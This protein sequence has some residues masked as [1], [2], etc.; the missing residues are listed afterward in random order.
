M[1]FRFE[2][3]PNGG[4]RLIGEIA[5]HRLCWLEGRNG[6]GKTLAVRLLQLVTGE[7]PYANAPT[8]WRSLREHLGPTTIVVT[9]F[10][11][12]EELEVQL[13]PRNWPESPI[14]EAPLGTA[15]LDGTRISFQEVRRL[16][17]VSRI[18]GDET[19]TTRFKDYIGTDAVLVGRHNERLRRKTEELGEANDALLAAMNGLSTQALDEL[20]QRQNQ[21]FNNRREVADEYRK[22]T[23][24]VQELET[25]E[26]LTE[27]L[28]ELRGQGP[29]LRVSLENV[30]RRLEEYEQRRTALEAQQRE[31]L[32][33]VENEDALLSERDRLLRRRERQEANAARDSAKAEGVLDELRLPNDVSAVRAALAEAEAE[34][35]ELE[36]NQAALKVPPDVAALIDRVRSPLDIVQDSAISAEVIAVVEDH[37]I[38]AN[39]LRDGL[40]RRKAE[41][42]AHRQ[43]S[44]QEE[45]EARIQALDEKLGQLRKAGRLLDSVERASERIED[46]EHQINDVSK[47]LEENSSDKYKEVVAELDLVQQSYLDQVRERASLR[48]KLELMNRLGSESE[49]ESRTAVLGE[50]LGVSATPTQALHQARTEVVML[51]DRLK[52]ADK[53]LEAAEIAHND[54]ERRLSE[55]TELM[56]NSSAYEWLRRD[57]SGRVPSSGLALREALGRI[58]NLTSA[59]Q[60][61]QNLLNE[62]NTQTALVQSAL[63]ELISTRTTTESYHDAQSLAF[64]R[65]LERLTGHYEERFG[66]LLGDKEVQAALFEEGRFERLDLSHWE[67]SWTDAQG[68]PQRRPI[69]AFSSGERAF[70]YVLASVLQHAEDKATNRLLVLDEFGAF[71]EAERLNRLQRF[72]NERVLKADLADQ[73][74]VIL[75][76]REEP[77]DTTPEEQRR[78]VAIRGYFMREGTG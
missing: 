47:S 21:A 63:G 9:D 14:L 70:A 75:P 53:E 77:G 15:R 45:V 37:R 61:L 29:G 28:A 68:E 56:E 31:L 11:D 24:D 25:L 49:L 62:L 41:V 44:L 2:A 72:L 35:V 16:L 23:E 52:E 33:V 10:E 8:A 13:T 39:E 67:V 26:R 5:N 43:H 78:A 42:D 19:I 17:K 36:K 22:K 40:I 4:V 55:T 30:E 20:E 51:L 60:R 7:Q 32:S 58:E 57:L 6:I 69:E 48:S 74:V 34:R 71:I 50:K 59:A 66:N 64:R 1:N 38:K 73:I 54:F 65:H 76:L 3:S 27:A 12:G 46:T 18:A